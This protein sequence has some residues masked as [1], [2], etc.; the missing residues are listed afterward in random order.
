LPFALL[1][2]P[3][4]AQP[5]VH[6]TLPA[7]PETCLITRSMA[8]AASAQFSSFL[9]ASPVFD[10]PSALNDKFAIMSPHAYP[11]LQDMKVQA[12]Y[13]RNANIGSLCGCIFIPWLMFCGMSAAQCF[14]IR[15]THPRAV[16]FVWI[17][18]LA[19]ILCVAATL[20]RALMQK[21]QPGGIDVGKAKWLGFAVV[22]LLVAFVAGLLTGD[23]N[24]WTNFQQFYEGENLQYYAN[25]DPTQYRGN[26]LM[27]A[28]RILFAEGAALNL[29]MA[30]GFKNLD[31]YCI[32]PI[33]MSGTANASYDFW[34]VGLNC[35]GSQGADYQCGEFNNPKARSGLRLMRDDHRP[36][37]R[38][39]AMQAEA[40]YNIA[41]AHP[42]FFYW[43]EDPLTEAYAYRD[44]GVKRYIV[45]V[46]VFFALDVFF[47][48]VAL[49]FF[50]K[51][52]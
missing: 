10:H 15:Y 12:Q 49:I 28:G 14:W 24:Y 17:F 31:W 5:R 9:Q 26:Q 51:V 4:L 29:N 39:A 18:C 23:S 44:D 33:A 47:S 45:G 32:A 46:F 52:G 19:I 16:H 34:A 20:A 41:V 25:V 2:S 21:N 37:F 50:S 42:I 43:M 11:E 6:S 35:C 1:V 13:R 3:R 38:L 30:M 22:L 48:T 8:G 7:R 27:D 36:F 40:K